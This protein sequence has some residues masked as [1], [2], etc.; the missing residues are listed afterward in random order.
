MKKNF[1]LSISFMA[2]LTFVSCLREVGQTTATLPP[3]IMVNTTLS[4]SSLDLSTA[5]PMST[6]TVEVKETATPSSNLITPATS[7]TIVPMT[8]TPSST[9]VFPAIVPVT[10]T[11]LPTL[12]GEELE[13]SVTE[14]L[15]DPMNCTIPCWW[16]YVPGTTSIDEIKYGI[17]PY[18][19]DVYEYYD[20]EGQTYL[21]LGIKYLEE[22]ND[23][24]VK[25]VFRF[26]NS[27]LTG[28]TAYSP[29]ISELLNKF[30]HPDEVWVSAM[31]D[32][33]EQP[34]II[35]F[36]IV[37]LQKG[38]GIGYVVDGNVQDDMT[39]GCVADESTERLRSLRLITPDSATSYRDFSVIYDKAR[40]YLPLE[41]AT[42][43]TIEDF[44]QLFNEPTQAQCIETPIELWE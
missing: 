8:I 33:R 2:M 6:N 11:P 29:P 39:I 10:L 22:Q 28:I 42:N 16:G 15:A 31:N 27:I 17:S 20:E 18:N 44:V 5:S 21:R 25:I 19:F 1:A 12:K 24:D 3:I 38:L 43:S 30:G 40:L 35:W 26:S 7:P 34:P 4:Q 14:L 41:Q 37:Y 9:L 36:I 32:P 13:S 23:F